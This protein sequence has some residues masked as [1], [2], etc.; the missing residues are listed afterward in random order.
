MKRY[1]PFALL[2]LVILSFL[3]AALPGEA[4]GA[5]IHPALE[6]QMETLNW[7]DPVSVILIMRDQAPIASLNETL[8]QERATRRERHERVVRA[9]R[10]ASA[11]QADLLSALAERQTRGDVRGYTSHWIANLVVAQVAKA[12]VYELAARADIDVIEPNF[13]VSLIEPVGVPLSGDEGRGIGVTP[14]L[15]AINADR[16]WYELG[17]TGAGTIVGN[18]DTGVDGNHP[19]LADRWRGVHG[20]PASECWLNLIGGH[21]NFPHDGYRHGTHVMGTITGLGAATE[22]TIGV[23]WNALWIATDP[24]N[25]GPGSEFDQD[26]IDAY[27]WFADPDGDPGTVDEVPDVVQNSWRV[28][29]DFGYP[30][31]DTR[32]WEVIDNCEAA[33]VVTTWSAGNEGPPPQTIGSPADRATTLT[34]AFSVGAIDATHYSYPYPIA[35]FSSRGPSGCDVPDPNKIKP[36]VVAPGVEVYSSVPGGGYQQVGWN[37]TSMAGPHVAGVVALIREANPDLDVDTIKEI[38]MLTAVDHGDPGEDNTYGWG[39]IDAFEAVVA[40]MSGYGTLTG[41]V[42]NASNG[43]TP[44]QGVTIEAVEIE[45][46]TTT[47]GDGVY[48]ISLP[49]DTYT[50]AATHPSFAPETAYNVVVEEGETTIQDFSMID[51]AGP[52]ITNT[53]DPR[54]TEN[55]VGPYLIE[56]TVTD[57]STIDDVTLYYRINGGEF[58]ALPMSS[59]GDDLFGAGIPGQPQTTH[60]EYYIRA[61]DVADNVS[62]DPCGAPKDLYDFWVAPMEDLFSDDMESGAPDWTHDVVSSGYSDQ[63]HLS[64]QRNHTPDGATSWKCGDTGAGNYANLLDAG[65]V[66]PPMELTADSYLH[67]WQWIDAEVSAAHTGYAYDGG[68]IEISSGGAAW[69]QIYPDGGYTYLIREGSI[70]G[71]FPVETEVFSGQHD[72]HEVHFNLSA[73]SGPVQLRFRFGSDGADACEGWYVDDVVVDGFVVDLSAVEEQPPYNLLLL[74]GADPNPFL[75]RT[76]LRYRLPS[77][78]AVLLQVFDLSGR[79]IRTLADGRQAPGVYQVDWDGCDDGARPLP[80]GVYLTRLQAGSAQVSCKMILTR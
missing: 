16:V 65:L 15:R 26:I 47:A 76:T 57:F 23:A 30:D 66:T 37:G 19:A 48:S 79:L 60:V 41:T 31:C 9:L 35:N 29:E 46:Q 34:N 33:G 58:A 49:A 21:P 18:C 55:T 75:N 13:T 61:E 25:Q 59:A 64:I 42:T 6:R 44:I 43:G 40:A 10:E 5:A 1:V 8:K 38:I 54:S 74:D 28:N 22:D 68:L 70:P 50:V 20:H 45:R 78:A 7:S 24:I 17:I 27:E 73:Y 71:P 36:E 69:V 53:T 32:W 62:T 51:I 39:V 80:C 3:A 4:R 77:S 72:W 12:Y 52:E 14:G 63:W 67:Y 11:S 56:S 2:C